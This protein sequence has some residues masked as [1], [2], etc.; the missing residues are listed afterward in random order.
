MALFRGGSSGVSKGE[1]L[2]RVRQ[3]QWSDREG[4]SRALTELA[5][6]RDL[7]PEELIPLLESDEPTVR[8]F[9]EV[10]VKERLD[11][12][13]LDAMI[14]G[15]D[16][17]TTRTQSLILHTVLRAK[18]DLAAKSVQGL[19]L[20][21]DRSLSRMAMEALS[22]LPDHLI[23]AE[24]TKFLGHDKAEIRRMALMK[25]M[26]SPALKADPAVR[27]AF[28][29]MADDDDERI[30]TA[31]LGALVE[32]EPGEAVRLALQR[33][34]DPSIAIQQKAVQVLSEALNRIGQST[35]A[36]DQL[37]DLLTDGSEAVRNGVLDII[38]KRPDRGRLLRKLL[39]FCKGLMG[40]MRDR[41][42]DSLRRYSRELMTPVLE[43]MNDP[44]EDVRSMALLLGST[45]EAREAVPHIIRLLQDDDWWV[46]MIAAETLGKIRDERAVGPLIAAMA[47]TDSAMACIEAL[48]RIGHADALI[49]ICEALSRP[50]AE[51]RVEALDALRKMRDPRVAPVLEACISQD[52]SRAVRS[53]AEL[54]LEAITGGHSAP[55]VTG[56]F[57]VPAELRGRDVENL[58][59]LERLMVTTREMDGSDLHVIVNAKPVVR[60]HGN[61]QE[62]GDQPEY[63]AELAEEHLFQIMSPRLID[64]LHAERQVDFCHMIPEIGRYRCNVYRER[65]GWA[66]AFRTIP[67]E[68]PT[69][70]DVG[71]PPHLADLVNYHQGLIVV[72]GPSGSGKSTTLAALV[73]LFN[74]QKRA[75]LLS[76]EDPI[77]F[78]HSAKGC[79]INQREVGRHTRSFASA[80]RGALR[81][82]PD[83]IVVGQMR[84][85]ETVRLAIEASETGHLVIG[86]MNT[87]SAPKT[88]DRIVESFP[89]GEQTQIRVMLS[90]TLKAVV[91]QQLLPNA[92]DD[93]RVALFEVMMGTLGVR[94][95]IRDNKTY[96]IMSQ[97]QIGETRGHITI[98]LALARLLEAGQ[99]SAEEAY[100]RAQS[101]DNFEA[102]VGAE[103]LQGRRERR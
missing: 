28:I 56:S 21:G 9:A 63:T 66:G 20:T 67:N 14:R 5:A 54:A 42:L 33:I 58:G 94:M 97:M 46:R 100:R 37:L 102:R 64:R 11:A 76:L 57:A 80:L 50:E 101:K 2:K 95:L 90:E 30:R 65:K 22:S 62:L 92:S 93:G 99:I 12:R 7:K 78:V 68:V 71:L 18:P 59:P 17:K 86:T 79:L 53:R 82:D 98:D 89:V 81:E 39:L 23:G 73:N 91:C 47:D 83:I 60:V 45:L 29:A 34:K 88:V 26:D 52:P 74:E 4:M 70:N 24:F 19:V 51:I 69:L 48:S 10:Q 87:T 31:I 16:G 40:W 36:E 41:T 35:E 72:A 55:S 27:R 85:P 77:E 32:L 49:P 8:S 15:L 84:D 96:Q 13:G 75:H 3:K 103:F 61:L 1:A 25:V 43:L 44:D 6:C 38:I